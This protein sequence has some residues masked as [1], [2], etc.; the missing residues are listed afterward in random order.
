MSN[1]VPLIQVPL[2]SFMKA[3][4]HNSSQLEK[5]R[6][7]KAKRTDGFFLFKDWS[8]VRDAFPLI[9]K[10]SGNWRLGRIRL[11]QQNPTHDYLVEIY[12]RSLN[13][14]DLVGTVMEYYAQD[15]TDLAN[16]L[17]ELNKGHNINSYPSV[18]EVAHS[19]TFAQLDFDIV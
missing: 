17:R 5:L 7:S 16:V 4:D 2:N 6:R 8:N 11:T 9:G 12:R 14:T 15:D 19:S 13:K 10:Y 3:F 1:V 18:W